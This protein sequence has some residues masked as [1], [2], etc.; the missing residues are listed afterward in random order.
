[1]NAVV[2]ALSFRIIRKFQSE[3]AKR[4]SEG[5]RLKRKYRKRILRKK[6][7]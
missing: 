3:L 6:D 7:R 1:M 2:V 5:K 4:E